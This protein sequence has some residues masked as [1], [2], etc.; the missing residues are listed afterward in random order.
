VYGLYRWSKAT[1][2]AKVGKAAATNVPRWLAVGVAAVGVFF[3]GGEAGVALSIGRANQLRNICL[4]LAQD[5]DISAMLTMELIAS[6]RTEELYDSSEDELVKCAIPPSR[7]AAKSQAVS[8]AAKRCVVSLKV[9]YSRYP[10][11][12]ANLERR[13]PDVARELGLATG[14]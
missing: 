11:R 9:F 6:G 5:R 10:D 7:S 13:K 14:P 12:K 4:E 3:I 8:Q 2:T 1:T